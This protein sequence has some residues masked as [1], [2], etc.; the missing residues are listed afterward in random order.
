MYV[1]TDFDTM[2]MDGNTLTKM[3]FKINKHIFTQADL[4]KDG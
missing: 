4:S 2:P 1:S 3:Y